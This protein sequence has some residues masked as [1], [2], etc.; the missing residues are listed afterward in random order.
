MARAGREAG[1]ALSVEAECVWPA[2]AR[3]GECPCWDARSGRVFWV[4]I[5]RAALHAFR[6]VDG[7]RQTW[8]LPARVCSLDVPPAGWRPPEQLTGVPFV[9]C[10]DMGF[11]WIGVAGD[12]V[13]IVTLVHPERD[14]RG[15]RFNDGKMGPDGRY[16]AGTMDDAEERATGR[17]YAFRPDGSFAVLDSGY[18]VSNGPAFSPDGSVVYHADSARRE[19]YAFDLD[20]DGALSG[21]RRLVRFAEGEGHPDGMTTDR[22]GNLW[23]AMWDGARVENVSP[24]GARVG[25]IPVPTAKPTSCTFADPDCTEMY[26]TSASIG[27]REDDGLAGALFR[28]RLG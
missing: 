17:L 5:K 2:R 1:K 8:A 15:N 26:V 10:G 9:G 27:L 11:A 21:K 25:S 7:T 28:A 13:E 20:S 3:L 22:E 24:E 4:D 19:I 6:S 14:Q 12:A 16:W 23:V 18:R